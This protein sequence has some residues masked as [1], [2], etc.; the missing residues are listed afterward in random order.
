MKKT[1]VLLYP[2]FSEYELT[3]ALSIL[4]QG[5]KDMAVVGLTPDPVIGEA[6]LSCNVHTTI[7]ALD[8]ETV[9]SLVLPGCDDIGYLKD[10]EPLFA[11][12][13][14]IAGKGAILAAI[15]SAPFLLA[16]AGVLASHRYTVGFTQEQRDYIGVFDE[17]HYVDAPL[18]A[19][20]RV[21]TAKGG[22]FVHFG[23]QLGRMLGLDFDVD[24]YER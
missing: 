3:V 19:D 7:H 23:I 24:W 15:S 6:G 11:F 22:Y 14:A 5:D 4:R 10:A 17:N 2:R 13:Q 9:D 8:I 16:R 12:I 18:V 1:A 21:L 20:G